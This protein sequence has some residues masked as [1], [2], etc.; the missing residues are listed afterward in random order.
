MA[1]KF[2]MVKCGKCKN[3]QAVFERPSSQVKCLVCSEVLAEPT[4]GKAIV[5]GKAMGEAR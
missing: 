3:E 4:G 5:K 2:V 1:G